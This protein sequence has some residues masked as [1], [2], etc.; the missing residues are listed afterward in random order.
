MLLNFCEKREVFLG[1]FG[2]YKEAGKWMRIMRPM[3]RIYRGRRVQNAM[4]S[5]KVS[6]KDGGD[7]GE[8]GTVRRERG[9]WGEGGDQEGLSGRSR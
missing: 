1:G 6:D 7:K 5:G 8:T 9:R 2:G 3:L 4:F